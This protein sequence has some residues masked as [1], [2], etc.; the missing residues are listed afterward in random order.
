MALFLCAISAQAALVWKEAEQFDRQGG[1]TQDAQFVDQMGSPYLLAAGFNGPVAPAETL[2]D[3][4]RAGT[5]HLWVRTRDWFPQNSPGLFAV[6]VAGKDS[7]PLGG[8]K[9][10]GWIW[11]YGGS[12]SLQAGEATLQLKDLAGQYAR[13]DVVVLTDD[14]N[15]NGPTSLA[16]LNA[17]RIAH[18]GLSA[19]IE[20]KGPYDLVVTGGGMGGSCTAI[21]AARAGLKVAL[22]Q[23]RPV[24]GGNASVEIKIGSAGDRV[25]D[26]LDPGGTGLRDEI[27]GRRGG[28][29]R[30][31]SDLAQ[32]EKTLDVFLNTHAVGVA[33]DGAQKI[34][35]VYAVNVLTGQRLLFSGK[36]F[37]DATGDANIAAAAKAEF[38]QGREPR[39]MYGESMAPE[40]ADSLLMCSSLGYEA[41]DTGKSVAFKPFAWAHHFTKPSDFSVGRKPKPEKG[42]W[43]LEYGG[44]RD[45]V[46][47]AEEI[48]D[49][50]LRIIFGIWN[51]LKNHDPEKRAP[52]HELVWV[53]NIVG[54]RESRRV[55]G[56][57][58]LNQ[59]DVQSLRVFEDQVAYGAFPIDL[60]PSE[61]FFS[62]QP[63]SN[64]VQLG[65]MFTIPLRSL[66]SKDIENL[67]LVGRCISASHVAFG[68]ARVQATNGLQG[69]AVG[70]AAALCLKFNLTPRQLAH[71]RVAELQQ[72][73]LKNGAYLV[74]LPNSD[75]ADLAR[76]AAK[77]DASSFARPEDL[78]V[79]HEGRQSFHN[80][81][82]AR[83]TLFKATTDRTDAVDVFLHNRADK[84]TKLSVSLVR[85]GEGEAADIDA[86]DTLAS[87]TV[88]VPPRHFG[89]VSVPIKAQLSKGRTYAL[90]LKG[91][92]TLR[93]ATFPELPAD[94]S[95]AYAG[96]NRWVVQRDSAYQFRLEPAAKL[97]PANMPTV[98][99]GQRE[100]DMFVPQNIVN[101]FA[102]AIRGWPN[103]WRPSPSAAAPQWVQLSWENPQTFNTVHVSFQTREL[104]PSRYAIEAR[105]DGRWQ[106][107]AEVKGNEDRRVVHTFERVSADALRLTMREYPAGAGVCEIRVYDEPLKTNQTEE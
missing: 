34:G 95:R 99:Q 12:F 70:V 37:V 32:K 43:W 74:N 38:R 80:L 56:D 9:K 4:P 39:E 46:A 60:H 33:M 77:V 75:P 6:N 64:A 85:L 16:D 41:R 8:G 83:A 92:A 65:G 87:K 40:Q 102:R 97:I 103:S 5:Y 107:L 3:I 73:L 86:G 90:V 89:W 71:T 13:C 25:D 88:V 94:M 18:G 35:G 91:V 21:A 69:E 22:I 100:E 79:Q 48:R 63:P 84:E 7:R 93:W 51:Y 50:L 26:A 52:N 72:R 101:G 76:Q 20:E 17:L 28:A 29:T 66:Y 42:E 31:L 27:R 61:G 45:T 24:L 54:K 78:R 67:F 82:Q 104:S 47:E 15:W 53:G 49:E 10:N 81:D 57:Y 2:V 19:G 105:V 36:L 55:M 59:N 98:P 68:A 96:A 30:L 44:T 58:V 14:P 1:W 11:E 23:N 106:P 62:D